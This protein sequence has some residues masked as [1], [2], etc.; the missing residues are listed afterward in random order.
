MN[1]SNE[2]LQ[3]KKAILEQELK[4]V[5]LELA[6]VLNLNDTLALENKEKDETI[7]MKEQQLIDLQEKD[8]QEIEQYLQER[9]CLEEYFSHEV[10]VVNDSIKKLVDLK[11]RYNNLETENSKLAASTE[12]LKEKM[13]SDA[14]VHAELLH[15]INRNMR[16]M[17]QEMEATFRKELVE[18]DLHFQ[19]QAFEAMDDE[20]KKA[21]LANSKLKDELALQSVGISNLGVRCGRDRQQFKEIKEKMKSIGAQVNTRRQKLSD[22]QM[23]KMQSGLNI[24][25]F[26]AELNV[27]IEKESSLKLQLD[28][29]PSYDEL[30]EVESNLEVAM[31]AQDRMLNV[32]TSRMKKSKVVE[33]DYKKSNFINSTKTGNSALSMPVGDAIPCGETLGQIKDCDYNEDLEEALQPIR[34]KESTLLPAEATVSTCVSQIIHILKS[35]VRTESCDETYSS[36]T[37][38][39]PA[40]DLERAQY[41]KELV[42]KLK[43]IKKNFPP[44]AAFASTGVDG[45]EADN[46]SLLSQKSAASK[47][48]EEQ[49]LIE[50]GRWLEKPKSFENDLATSNVMNIGRT[51]ELPKTKFT[52]VFLPNDVCMEPPLISNDLLEKMKLSSSA[53]NLRSKSAGLLD[54]M[55]TTSNTSKKLKKSSKREDPLAVSKVK[56]SKHSLSAIN[57]RAKNSKAEKI[58]KMMS[59]TYST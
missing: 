54:D 16:T 19:R 35:N 20:K 43:K 26:E 10:D 30:D 21:M 32:W 24:C 36:S 29:W 14:K 44:P 45:D 40:Q 4:R 9:T 1:S 18:M 13:S 12:E 3:E 33:N 2:Q 42:N 11:Q 58:I 41:V 46:V 59:K 27:A 28:R 49:R 50:D 53:P 51:S 6:N 52:D 23:K 34:G 22:L 25:T 48:R 47:I 39:P 5:N 31:R 55:S 57:L 8:H 17:R 7:G 15:N 56:H 37:N 38:V